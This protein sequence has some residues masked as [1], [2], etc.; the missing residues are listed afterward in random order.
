MPPPVVLAVGGSTSL[1]AE[2]SLLLLPAA[3]SGCSRVCLPV[4]ACLDLPDKSKQ[5]GLASLLLL[6]CLPPH[7][8]SNAL[9]MHPSCTRGPSFSQS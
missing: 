7:S 4:S 6:P 9:R 3:S 2:R 5:R 8:I 1:T